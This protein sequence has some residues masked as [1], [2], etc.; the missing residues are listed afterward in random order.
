MLLKTV[1]L[2]QPKVSEDKCLESEAADIPLVVPPLL[3]RSP[4]YDP[5]TFQCK[6]DPQVNLFQSQPKKLHTN[7]FNKVWLDPGVAA[8]TLYP[9][10]PGSAR[11]PVDQ[12]SALCLRRESL[13][14]I[15]AAD[16]TRVLENCAS[17]PGS[18]QC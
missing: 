11:L 8:G 13:I 5:T 14:N 6:L 1:K 12:P 2:G 3:V 18:A 4:I 10:C 16:Q 7:K 9:A 15:M 17:K